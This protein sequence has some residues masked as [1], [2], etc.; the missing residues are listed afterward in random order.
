MNTETIVEFPTKD[1]A[2][3]AEVAAMNTQ[4]NALVMSLTGKY[5]DPNKHLIGQSLN[6]IRLLT[7][8]M[9]YTA[10]QL[11]ERY[12]AALGAEEEAANEARLHL[13]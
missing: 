10:E 7:H 13:E 3:V 1:D 12:T 4:V 2:A 11:Y 5:S 6:M 9:S 8:D